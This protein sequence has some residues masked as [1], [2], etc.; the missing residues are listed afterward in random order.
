MLLFGIKLYETQ[1]HSF[2]NSR[3]VNLKHRP[4]TG[5]SLARSLAGPRPT[6]DKQLDIPHPCSRQAGL[7]I[8][9]ARSTAFARVCGLEPVAALDAVWLH[10]LCFAHHL[11]LLTLGQMPLKAHTMLQV[12]N[13]IALL[14]AIPVDST[15]ELRTGITAHRR[16]PKGVEV[17]VCS[18]A[19]ANNRLVWANSCAYFFPIKHGGLVEPGSKS[20]E[21]EPLGQGRSLGSWA[22]GQKGWNF[23]RLSG[24]YNGIHTSRRY[25]R[26]RGFDDMYSHSQPLLA[27]CLRRLA[28]GSAD[29][30][31]RLDAALKGPVFYGQEV[32]LQL[33]ESGRFDLMAK[34]NGRPVITGR[35]A[36]AGLAHGQD[37]RK[38][39]QNAL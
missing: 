33:D 38:E 12:R 17:D 24:D 14:E 25:A 13:H 22:M 35:Y 3:V 10:T 4:S 27:H 15:L 6:F 7:M 20:A 5:A 28:N 30:A 11:H 29:H 8:G 18:N 32:N 26:L 34:G 23:A 39:K 19:L 36:G 1:Y 16:R 21:F 9:M 37:G 31:F 2:E